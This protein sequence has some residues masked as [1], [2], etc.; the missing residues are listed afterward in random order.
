[1]LVRV[2]NAAH[3][4]ECLALKFGKCV[5]LLPINALTSAALNRSGGGGGGG[6]DGGGG[7]GGVDLVI[8]IG[9]SIRT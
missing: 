1:M 4:S 5:K 3:R 9:V 8:V 6:G 7:E 2:T